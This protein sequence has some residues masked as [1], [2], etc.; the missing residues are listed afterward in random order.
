MKTSIAYGTTQLGTG[1][2]IW[3]QLSRYATEFRRA[4]SRRR[5]YNALAALDDR[6]LCDIGVER[7]RIWEAVDAALEQQPSDGRASRRSL[8]A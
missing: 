4:R 6:T 1:E 7:N 5:A 2:I 8:A 3:R